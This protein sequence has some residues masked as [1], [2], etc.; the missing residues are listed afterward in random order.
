MSKKG[1]RAIKT[2]EELEKELKDT[3]IQRNILKVKREIDELEDFINNKDEMEE[4]LEV[5]LKQ[6]DVQNLRERLHYIS[7]KIRT[8]NSDLSEL[9]ERMLNNRLKALRSQINIR[10]K[11]EDKK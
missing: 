2:I 8:D 3:T 7:E 4:D 10:K 11:R 6:I 9:S 5:I 1:R